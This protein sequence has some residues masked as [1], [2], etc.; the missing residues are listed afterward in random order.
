[1][2]KEARGEASGCVGSCYEGLEN[3]FDDFRHL[4]KRN[5]NGVLDLDIMEMIMMMVCWVMV[6]THP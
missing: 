3:L 2:L 5:R 4:S 6:C 1:M